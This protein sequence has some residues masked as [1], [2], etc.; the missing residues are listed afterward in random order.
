MKNVFKIF[1]H[2]GRCTNNHTWNESIC[3]THII[4]VPWGS[5]KS[6][7][8]PLSCFGRN[9]ILATTIFQ[10]V[11]L[12]DCFESISKFMHFI[13]IA[14]QHIRDL[15]N[16]SKYFILS[17]L[18]KFHNLYVLGSK[19]CN[20]WKDYHLSSNMRLRNP[21]NLWSA[22]NYVSLAQVICGHSLFIKAEIPYSIKNDFRRQTKHQSLCCHLWNYY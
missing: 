2:I 5:I 15:I 22:A 21:Q 9:P 16:L 17:H 1:F 3:R 19:Y 8:L 7:K 18:R 4:Q 20:R 13:L 10:Y 14:R 11:I 12:I 6:K